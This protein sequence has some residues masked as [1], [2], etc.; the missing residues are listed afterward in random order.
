MLTPSRLRLAALLL[1]LLP[2]S[3]H[4]T[5]GMNM[6]AWGAKSGGMGGA[7]YGFD[8]GNSAVMNNPATLAL[9]E[10]ERHD[11]GLGITALLPTVASSHPQAG[12]RDSDGDAYYM[13]TV[14]WTYRH[15][16]WTYG[17]AMLAQGGMGTEYGAGSSLFAGGRSMNGVMAPMSGEDIRSEVG[18]G[19]LMFP[20]AFRANDALTV[21]AQLDFVWATMDVKMDVDGAT[22]GRLVAGTPGTGRAT[23]SLVNAFNG[24]IGAG[25]ISDVHYA[26]FDFSDAHDFAGQAKGTG[27]AG[28]LGI[29]YKLSESLA[30]GA[31]WHS[32]T[33]IDDLA[34]SKASVQ[35]GVA[36][37]GGAQTVPVSGKI[38]V[39]D[40]QWPETY[41]IGLAWQATP[42]LLLAADLKSI[43]WAKSMQQFAMKFEADAVQ[44]NPMAQMLVAGG[45][46]VMTAALEQSW[47]NHTV[48]MLGG[49]YMYTPDLAL[50]AGINVAANPV[51]DGTLNPLFPATVRHHYTFGFGL[52]LDATSSLAASV[53]YAPRASDT[54]DNTGIASTHRQ[55]TLRVNYNFSY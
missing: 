49:Q 40:F 13:P 24:A 14:S 22:F 48:L 28:K 12:R 3:A 43:R 46:R 1:P 38:S 45:G 15:G 33:H 32:K 54:N 50:R 27:W 51:P 26:R 17:A 47:K 8:S 31:T 44:T 25:M 30:V 4:A 18:V 21:A 11:V 9:R 41:G 36:T 52:R 16:P 2:L 53:A 23:G 5:N 42:R 35:M 37:P 7:S 10:N 55:T 19:R 39:L 6:D 34:A 29:H 20:L